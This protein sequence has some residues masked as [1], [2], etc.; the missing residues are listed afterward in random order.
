MDKRLDRLARRLPPMRRSLDLSA[1]SDDE[2]RELVVFGE[3]A[4]VGADGS[5][6]LDRLTAAHHE[7]LAALAAKAGCTTSPAEHDAAARPRQRPRPLLG[8]RRNP[9]RGQH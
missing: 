6:A 5:G 8:A 3:L 9:G 2:V 7:R 4:G 1:L